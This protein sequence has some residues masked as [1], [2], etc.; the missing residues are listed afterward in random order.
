MSWNSLFAIENANGRIGSSYSATGVALTDVVGASAVQNLASFNGL[1]V[2]IYSV[3]VS[4]PLANIAGTATALDNWIIGASSASAVSSVFALGSKS[5]IS[6]PTIIAAE[7]TTPTLTI[8]FILNNTTG[9][10]PIYINS[11]FVNGA[12]PN[13]QLSWAATLATTAT[14]VATKLA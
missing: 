13:A 11:N 9:T 10:T 3:F 7:T 14:F 6:F 1:P 2:G 8:D 12:N 5:V 4:V